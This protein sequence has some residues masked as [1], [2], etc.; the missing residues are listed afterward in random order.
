MPTDLAILF[1]TLFMRE[2]KFK[3]ESTKTPKYFALS[4]DNTGKLLMNEVK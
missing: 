3:R 2:L 4:Y 1:S